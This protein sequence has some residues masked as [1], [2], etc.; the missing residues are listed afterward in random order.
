MGTPAYMPPEQ[1]RGEVER[2]DERADVFSLG[3]ILCEILTGQPPV[4]RRADERDGAPQAARGDLADAT[5]RIERCGAD[6]ELLAPRE[7]V[8]RARARRRVPRTRASWLAKPARTWPRS[9]SGR[10]RPARLRPRLT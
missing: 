3:A 9:R 1:A 4:R 2:L 7:G 8:P 6:A 10:R 5:R